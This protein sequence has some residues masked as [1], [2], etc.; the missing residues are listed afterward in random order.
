M[1]KDMR[2]PCGWWLAML[3]NTGASLGRV[4]VLAYIPNQVVDDFCAEMSA[5][6]YIF[7]W[8]VEM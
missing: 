7:A 8:C 6:D 5:L 3:P 1:C 2:C 4:D